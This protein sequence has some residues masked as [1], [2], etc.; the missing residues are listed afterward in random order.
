MGWLYGPWEESMQKVWYLKQMNKSST[1]TSVVA[2]ML[3]QSQKVAEECNKYT[4][5]VTY[6]LAITKVAIQLQAEEKPTYDN[7][8]IHLG[9]FHITCAFFSMLG[10][11]LAES[12]GPHI[13]NETH[14]IEKGSLKSFLSG[15]SYN[16]CKRSHQLL[17]A[18]MEILHVQAFVDQYDGDRFKT[19]VSNELHTIHTEKNLPEHIA[20]EEFDEVFEKFKQYSK[21]TSEE[22]RRK[23]AQ[24]WFGYIAIHVSRVYSKHSTRRLGIIHLLFPENN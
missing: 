2:E 13:L 23:T 24:F 15:K 19:V 10:K 11:Y 3:K 5:S 17:E 14:V 16:R 21:N 1:S 18:A 20:G 7:V 12:G 6:D 8:F 4:I 9:P 22:V